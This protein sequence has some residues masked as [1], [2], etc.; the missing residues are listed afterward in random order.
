MIKRPNI[1]QVSCPYARSFASDRKAMMSRLLASSLVFALF[2]H[3]AGCGGSSADGTSSETSASTDAGTAG[4]SSTKDAT[5]DSLSEAGQD[6]SQDSTS[7]TPGQ[8]PV[9]TWDKDH[10][11]STPCVPWSD[12]LPG[13]YVVSEGTPSKDRVC[14]ACSG[15]YSIT[16][17]APFCS[18][19]TT[20]V[21]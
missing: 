2:C 13:Q 6:S 1:M 5:P 7:S 10:E 18:P 16:A 14:G 12:C 20:W 15:G 11:V 9:G 3:V 17:N 19:W 21:V 8:C 4:G